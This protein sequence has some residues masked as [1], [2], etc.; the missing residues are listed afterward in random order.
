MSFSDIIGQTA[1]VSVL[2]RSLATGR[3]AH[4]YIFN[5]IEGCGKRKTALAF[6]EAIFCNGVDS[7]GS[8]PACRKVAGLQHPDL[9]IIEPEGAFIKIDQIRDLQKELSYRPF[10]AQKK[11]CIMEAAD[12]LNPAAANAFLK[13]L[14][15][16]P[17]SALLILLTSNMG[18]VLPTILSRCQSLSFNPLSLD[19]IEEYLYKTGVPSETA[20]ISASLA[21]G[22]LQKA[23]EI[24]K[25]NSIQKRGEIL[26]KI[27]SLSQEEITT[28]FTLA[29]ELG[30]EREKT[31]EILDMLTLFWRDVLLMQSGLSEPVNCDIL[32]LLKKETAHT[33]SEKT[34]NKIE[35]ISRA[36]KALQRNVNPRLA[37]EVLFMGLAER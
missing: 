3:I 31:L 29:E 28:L 24:S 10:E 9:H 23:L 35:L 33:T 16:P 20:R 14:E 11:V 4:A 37:L 36:R 12:R 21:G 18:A 19:A 34:M 6:V 27:G 15:E 1:P 26:K 25:D 5:G 30:N 32:S 2:R 7:C 8:C 22:S 17:G 13:T